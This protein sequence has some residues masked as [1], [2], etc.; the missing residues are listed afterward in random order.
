MPDVE[1]ESQHIHVEDQ[2][3]ID[4]FSFSIKKPKS[5]MG[6]GRQRSIPKISGIFLTKKV[7]IATNPMLDALMK[8][9]RLRR[10]LF[11]SKPVCQ[12]RQVHEALN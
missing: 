12:Q 1:E 11:R 5:K 3:E 7:D 4:A 2:I 10:K 6:S 8:S 9:I